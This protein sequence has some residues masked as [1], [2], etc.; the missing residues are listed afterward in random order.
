MKK[1]VRNI[2]VVFILIGVLGACTKSL[3]LDPISQISN[4]SFWKT[5]NDVTGAL[6]GMYVRLRTQA[7][8]NLFVWGEARS[9]MMDRSLAGTAGYQ[10]F[11]LNELDRSNV[12]TI[13][14]MGSSTWQ[15]MYTV[16]HDANL[17][18]KYAPTISFSS[19][20]GKNQILAEAYAMRA[21]AYFV[22]TR[23]WGDLPLVIEP[24]EGYKPD[25]IMRERTSKEQIMAQIKSDLESALVLF[26]NSN[27]KTGRNM[28]SR[29]ATQALKAEVSLWSAKV[30]KGGNADFQ[31]ALTAIEE[32]EK[33]DVG[34]LDNYA[35]IFDYTNK[36]NKEIVMAIRFQDIEA[37]D[38]IYMNMYIESTY[39][40]NTTDQ[41][42][43]DLI[44]VVGGFP[45]WTLSERVRK[46]FI[47]TDQRQLGTFID[48]NIPDNKGGSVYYGTVV[49]KFNGTVI[50]GVR[51][52]LDDYVLYRYA[53]ILLMKA[54]A[55]NAL[56]IDP[57]EAMN[58]V[59]KRAYG[60]DY[61]NHTFVN[62]S[63]AENDE[64][65]LQERLL[66]LAV[67]GKRWWDLVRF[68]KAFDLVPS[69]VDR[70][71]KNYLL[72]FPISETTLS[73]EPKV[74]QNPG[75]N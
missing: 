55:Q 43:K 1:V 64:S 69:L 3:E 47:A 22:M 65:I 26:P 66:E 34:L 62:K 12:G 23:T 14:G 61:L 10:L 31:A 30:L 44:G 18:L 42:T 68:E 41:A 32:V 57:S 63:K 52:F 49:S 25:V 74:Q 2:V 29:P 35:S 24:T 13:Y 20:A 15:G 73:L 28:W 9:D 45:F 21:Y 38:N 7:V 72:L 39:M 8:G 56:G 36:G 58:K 19:E 6:N 46:Q 67:E 51:R 17:L 59:R 4:Q 5:E 16:V 33:A 54:E 37:T 53:D 70:K 27:F 11:Y 48:I 75:Y 71:G 40:N 60:A 50:G